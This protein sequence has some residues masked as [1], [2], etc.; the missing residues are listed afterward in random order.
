VTDLKRSLL[1][2]LSGD[3]NLGAC[4]CTPTVGDALRD[5]IEGATPSCPLHP[6]P[7]APAVALNDDAV[8]AALALDPQEK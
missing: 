6:A 8:L 7:A 2:A 1:A 3:P 4:R 5:A